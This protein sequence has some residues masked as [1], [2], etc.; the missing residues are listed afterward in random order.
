MPMSTWV[1]MVALGRLALV[2]LGLGLAFKVRR[3]LPPFARTTGP[4]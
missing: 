3:R 4:I 2:F 1:A